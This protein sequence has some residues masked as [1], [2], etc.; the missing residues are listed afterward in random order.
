MVMVIDPF[1]RESGLTPPRGDAQM[2]LSTNPG[3]EHSNVSALGGN[4]FT[5]TTPGEFELQ[6]ISIQG[7]PCE[8]NGQQNT[9]YLIEWDDIKICHLGNIV[10]SALTEEVKEAIG[11]P[12]VLFVPVGGAGSLDAEEAALVTS[13]IEPRIV[14]PMRYNVSGLKTK[15]EEPKL[16]IKEVGDEKSKP[17]EKFVFK[18]KDL[19][20]EQ[21]T[22]VY[23]A[24]A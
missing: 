1:S 8:S 3:P 16:F 18:K 24:H 19:P 17:E 11:T 21:T 15:L 5:I 10:K 4:P 13:Q 6:G 14:I 9:C 7:I 20:Q 23:L 22:L 12:D 2:V